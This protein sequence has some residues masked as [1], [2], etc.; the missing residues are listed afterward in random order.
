MKLNHYLIVLSI[1]VS[2]LVMHAQ[3]CTSGGPSSTADSN[4]ESV[5]I[6][7]ENGTSISYSGCP[8]SIGLEDQTGLNV[9]LEAN[10]SYTLSVQFGT[11]GGN[12]Y[13][14]GSVYIDFNQN[15]IFEFTELIGSWTG[16]PPTAISQFNF[17][18]PAGTVNGLSRMR[19]IQAENATNPID[20]CLSFTWGSM[21]DF[22]VNF[23]QGVDC[24]G[25]IGDEMGDP[26]EISALPFSESYS[27]GF[28]YTNQDPV[29][30]SPDIYYQ[31]IVSDY[32]TDFLNVSLCGS[33][34]DTYL[35]IQDLDTNVLYVNDDY[36]FCSPQSE[37]TFP[38]A[39]LDTLFIVVQG[40]GNNSG[41]YDITVNDAAIAT[42]NPQQA[43]TV[44]M[45]PNPAKDFIDITTNSKER[46]S[47]N[48]YNNAGQVVLADDIVNFK[49]IETLKFEAGVYIVTL[50]SDTQII[51]KK[52][53]V[54]P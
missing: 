8:G 9:D 5:Y 2:P 18:V 14:E 25:Y 38:I 21:T 30:N 31:I 49:R 47:L 29:Y 10:N 28:C 15:Q 22:S 36:G 7:G 13:G 42:N 44:E 54:K 11:C 39:G 3:Y 52:I 20:P 16:T 17:T 40:W 4:I 45:Y 19:V 46:M 1:C 26:R 6:A 33:T 53:I 35:S 43:L 37:L 48:I 50:K 12:Y 27:T 23:T 24:S 32:D 51:Q 34:F 41:D